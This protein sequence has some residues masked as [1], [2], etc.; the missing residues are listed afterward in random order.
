MEVEEGRRRTV[1]VEEEVGEEGGE[2][3]EELVGEAGGEGEENEE[4]SRRSNET[5]EEGEYRF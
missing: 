1:K 3:E 5:K 2:G 4:R